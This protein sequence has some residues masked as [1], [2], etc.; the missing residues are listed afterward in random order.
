MEPKVFPIA[1]GSSAPLWFCGILGLLTLG[2]ALIVGIPAFFGS[3]MVKFEVSHGGLRVRGDIYGRLIPASA[4]QPGKART[5]DP[6]AEA[7]YAPD[8][9]TNGIGLPNYQ[10]GWF[11]LARGSKALLFMT[12]WSRAVLVPTTEG[13]DL[14]ISPADPRAFLAAIER[15]T[16]A[17]ATFPI[18]AGAPTSTLALPA[19]IALVPLAITILLGFLAYSTRAVRFVVSDEGLRIRGDLFG[20][21]I[22][23]GSLRIDEARILN[24]KQEPTH[25]PWLRTFGTGMPGY[26]SGWFRLKDRGK[27]LLFLTDPSHAI[28]LPTTE[29]YSLLISPADPEA[30]LA[31]FKE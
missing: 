13:Y 16:A 1:R 2:V 26:S 29:G 6:G 25:R 19:L 18:A 22:P 3:R 31:A 28:D 30:F 14:L 15:P 7:G 23:R 12:D 9:R 21:L 11:R 20:R 5:L 17:V 8:S 27:G 24:L 4:L 10:S